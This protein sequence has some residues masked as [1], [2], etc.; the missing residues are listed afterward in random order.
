VRQPGELEEVTLKLDQDC[1]KT[2]DPEM[3][4][5]RMRTGLGTPWAVEVIGRGGK[6]CH[7][8]LR[9]GTKTQ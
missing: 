2:I 3:W 7:P 5:R 1:G 9:T 4:I 6:S 8:L